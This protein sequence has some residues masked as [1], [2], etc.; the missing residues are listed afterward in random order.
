MITKCETCWKR[1][2]CKVYEYNGRFTSICKECENKKT[3]S[4]DRSCT[5]IEHK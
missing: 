5:N 2:E 3:I 4:A 1:K